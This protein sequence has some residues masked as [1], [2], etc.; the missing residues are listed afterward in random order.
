MKRNKYQSLCL[1]FLVLFSLVLNSCQ[2]AENILQSSSEVDFS[3]P[4]KIQVDF[5][6]AVYNITAVF[7]NSKLEIN[8]IDE[9]D[10]MD[11]AYVSLTDKSYKITYKDMAFQG[12]RSSLTDSF[13]PCVLY[14]FLTSFEKGVV[15]DSYDKERKCYST[16]KNINGYFITFECYE[17]DDNKFYSME[18]K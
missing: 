8:F 16:K 4:K 11:G 1:I 13:L 3:F 7:N 17:T 9:K 15:L 6:E 14:S 18:I 5:N 2:F 12:E 10:L